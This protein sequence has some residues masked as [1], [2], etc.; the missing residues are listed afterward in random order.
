MNQADELIA[1][2]RSGKAVAADQGVLF[3]GKDCLVLPG[4]GAML[5]ARLQQPR[6]F[7]GFKDATITFYNGQTAI[8]SARTDRE[9]EARLLWTPPGEGDFTI[10]A[11]PTALPEDM[12]D[13]HGEALKTS[14]DIL[15]CVRPSSTPLVV[16]DLDHTI[17]NGSWFDVLTKDHPACIGGAEEAMERI[18][19]EYGV[20][21][22][23]LRPN[24][25]TR[26]TKEWLA[27]EGLPRGPL[28]T[29][30]TRDMFGDVAQIKAARI[31]A[32][33]TFFP[34]V[35]FGVGDNA[36]DARAYLACGM[37]A[38]LLARPKADA[39]SMRAKADEVRPME[40]DE[41]LQVV[42]QWR[43][44]EQGVFEGAKFPAVAFVQDMERKAAQK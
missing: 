3:Y 18:A 31:K 32:I 35:R 19:K 39:R 41:R 40:G 36:S 14:A 10:T 44:I 26:R 6:S 5:S 33:K 13:R 15:V 2:F 25:L 4:Q 20:V 43:Q 8:G 21:Y 37:T 11:R 12:L 16:I 28:L 17:V 34:D 9:G 27:S 29:C 42:S 7:K 38:Y 30:R 24:A 22:L 1:C 23:S